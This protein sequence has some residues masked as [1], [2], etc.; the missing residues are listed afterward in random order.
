MKS[1]SQL[2]D[3]P[4]V[5]S[6]PTFNPN[7]VAPAF[8]RPASSSNAYAS[9]SQ[10]VL[11]ASAPSQPSRYIPALGD[12]FYMNELPTTDPLSTLL[13]K[14]LPPHVRPLRD[15]SGAWHASASTTDEIPD[16]FTTSDA[17]SPITAETVRQA[18]ASNSWRK[19]ASLARE[20]I[21][22]YGRQTK[23]SQQTQLIEQ[24]RE[25]TMR[26]EEVLEWWTARVYS[27]ARLRLYSMLRSELDGLWSILEREEVLGMEG[28][29]PFTLRVVRAMEPKWRGDVKS[30]LEQYTVLI[31]SCK[32]QIRKSKGQQDEVRVW[33]T[34][35]VRLGLMLSFAL[36][37]V[38]DFSGAIEVL[39]PL[40][41]TSLKSRANETEAEVSDR[42]H[43]VIVASRIYIQAGDLSFATSLLDRISPLLPPSSPLHQLITQTHSIIS[44][45]SSSPSPPDP[46]PDSTSPTSHLNQAISTFYSAHLDL[47]IS[48]LESVLHTHPAL[49]ATADALVFNLATL[50]ELD[51][52]GDARVLER[53]RGLLRH[54]ARWA[55]E[56]G[57]G[58]SCF[59]L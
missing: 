44:T 53:K 10:P 41:E 1:S 36:A 12:A 26:L 52:G 51:K 22:E 54:V 56:P 6:T 37:E 29:V 30:T 3:R 2:S 13:Q 17:A 7:A 43:L 25:E 58:G 5:E 23:F 14:H 9:T 33:K 47:A 39:H 18:T 31:R 34:R 27:L 59:K 15:L 28:A 55:G 32:D 57:V 49:A 40:I 46:E 11:Q 38:K 24:E 4:G 42:L 20:R 21:E 35:A 16:P 50:Y 45:I 8:A 48:Q 19:I